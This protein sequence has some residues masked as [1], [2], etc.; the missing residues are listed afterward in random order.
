MPPPNPE[1]FEKGIAFMLLRAPYRSRNRHRGAAIV[2]LALLLPFLAL[3]FVAAVDF[4]RVFY[5]YVTVTNCARSGALYG[6][7]DASHAADTTGIQSAAKAEAPELSSA[8]NVNSSTGTD[9]AGNSFVSVTVSYPFQTI[10]NF[11]G[12][13]GSATV[14]RTMQMRVIPP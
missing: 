8:L 11:P 10:T 13:P 7:I 6:S 5:Y 1:R 12:I 4:G 14:G 2:E 3:M 9:S